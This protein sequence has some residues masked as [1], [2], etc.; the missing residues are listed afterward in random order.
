MNWNK[1]KD[2]LENTKSSLNKWSNK[3]SYNVKWTIENFRKKIENFL[4]KSENTSNSMWY[5]NIFKK[6]E[7]FKNILKEKV[8]LKNIWKIF[9]LWFFASSIYLWWYLWN[10]NG[11]LD[12]KIYTQPYDDFV[13]ENLKKLNEK[14]EKR[15]IIFYK[16]NDL[17]LSNSFI[18]K[19]N[20]LP[21]ESVPLP[22]YDKNW[23]L[24]DIVFINKNIDS[25]ENWSIISIREIIEKNYWLD[26]NSTEL[27]S[28][29][30]N[31]YSITKDEDNL[32]WE[33]ID[34]LRSYTP[35]WLLETVKKMSLSS[36]R[37]KKDSIKDYTKEEQNEMLEKLA[38]FKIIPA[39]RK[40]WLLYRW[41]L[42]E[43]KWYDE[44]WYIEIYRLYWYDDVE[45]FKKDFI[46]W[47]I[48]TDWEVWFVMW[49]IIVSKIKEKTFVSDKD[50]KIARDDLESQGI[51]M[52]DD[53]YTRS[54][55]LLNTDYVDFK[56][57]SHRV[58]SRVT[59]YYPANVN[60]SIEWSKLQTFLN[61]SILNNNL[62]K[63]WNEELIKVDWSVRDITK[64]KWESYWLITKDWI[65]EV[66]INKEIKKWNK[67]MR[68]ILEELRL[69]EEVSDKSKK[70]FYDSMVKNHNSIYNA[71]STLNYFL[72][73][74]EKNFIKEE[75][76]EK[77]KEARLKLNNAYNLYLKEGKTEDLFKIFTE[78][79]NSEYRSSYIPN[80]QKGVINA[81]IEQ[82]IIITNL[83][84]DKWYSI[85]I[86]KER[87]L[88][89]NE[90]NTIYRWHE[91]WD[92]QLH[93]LR[94]F[95]SELNR[96][97]IE[98]V[99][100]VQSIFNELWYYKWEI[101][102]NYEDIKET[103]I[104]YQL[105]KKIISKRWDK[106]TGNFWPAT[107]KK[108]KEEYINNLWKKNN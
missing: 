23:D 50:I 18:S 92:M 40:R 54:E 82:D 48:S 77:T 43:I 9:W 72:S 81:I 79:L 1:L 73:E 85:N 59:N 33:Y 91:I 89:R 13:T 106:W 83:L 32:K 76:K 90:Q 37:V 11:W 96:K 14:Y 17:S 25:W 57:K 3:I 94:I 74:Q 84:K 35:N 12:Q 86:Y 100:K 53:R 95:N 24:A 28:L 47:N 36:M 69:N 31:I 66:K 15:G 56:E 7:S 5:Q 101:S 19:N 60:A 41:E 2:F 65:D 52:W 21:Y 4:S 8:T 63:S 22:W 107:R 64:W 75:N 102:W 49:I 108:L 80:Y 71:F 78:L 87:S 67:N 55:F 27:K 61:I 46:G 39:D 51:K 98:D 105:D 44:N 38:T 26:D 70:F 30:Y 29:L 62:E 99:K 88:L 20:N 45:K 16:P 93:E 10:T 58:D 42:E 68:F 103:I 34:F 6:T 97:S 104:E